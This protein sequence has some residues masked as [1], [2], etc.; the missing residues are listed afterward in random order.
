MIHHVNIYYYRKADEQK[1]NTEFY[2]KEQTAK[3]TKN[4]YEHIIIGRVYMYFYIALLHYLYYGIG[5]V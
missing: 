5:V 1:N 4:I 2:I 3:D